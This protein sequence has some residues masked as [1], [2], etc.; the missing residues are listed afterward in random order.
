PS[1]ETA[2]CLQAHGIA[3]TASVEPTE[4]LRDPH[5]MARGFAAQVER[6]NGTTA[7]TLG[8]P[9]LI[10]GRRPNQFRRP[11]RL[12]EDNAYVFKEL[13]GLSDEEYDLLRAE[14]VMY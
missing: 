9:W 1:E 2:E 7:E 13:L 3:A 14:R 11:P 5:L 4:V 6:L 12:G 10:D 8:I